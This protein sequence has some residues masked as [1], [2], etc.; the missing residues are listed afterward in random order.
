[1]KT[2]EIAERIESFCPLHLSE[3]WDNCG[4]Q[5]DLNNDVRRIYVS[6][7]LTYQAVREAIRQKADLI[8][9]HHPM[10]MQPMRKI[11]VSDGG[12]GRALMLIGDR[13]S[14]YS[15]HTNFDKCEGGNNDFF[16]QVLG[17]HPIKK[18]SEEEAYIRTASLLEPMSL[19]DAAQL[20]ADKLRANRGAVRFIGFPG[21]KVQKLAWC[22]GGGADR[23]DTVADAGFDLFITGDVRHHDARRAEDR[24]L[25]VID[26]GHYGTELLFIRNMAE[27]L[28]ALLSDQK[29]LE[30]IEAK[31]CFNPFWHLID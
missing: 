23:I 30:V 21:K 27:R 2:R 14:V 13:I 24:G 6:L 26:A 5:I 20:V 8:V 16:G 17:L 15:A 19:R 28:R 11:L 9:C 1:M 25:A 3:S 22:T 4:F 31:E 12:M 10:M 7:E 18:L 29:N